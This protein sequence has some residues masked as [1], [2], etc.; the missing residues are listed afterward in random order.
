[1]VPTLVHRGLKFVPR[2]L[3]GMIVVGAA[4]THSHAFVVSHNTVSNDTITGT[5]EVPTPSFWVQAGFWAH[6]LFWEQT[7]II[8]GAV[9][10][11][12]SQLCVVCL[13]V[14]LLERKQA[15]EL[16]TCAQSCLLSHKSYK[17]LKCP[18]TALISPCGHFAWCKC[19]Y[20][21]LITSFWSKT[22][23]SFLL[24]LILDEFFLTCVP[25]HERY[26]IGSFRLTGYACMW[27]WNGS[28]K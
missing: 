28:R 13:L 20:T 26:L 8:L 1:M 25:R 22:G 17:V 14:W 5:G 27:F 3:E 11:L 19:A 12:L 15:V 23:R 10:S 6:S 24:S 21:C 18:W 7:Q 9:E 4:V 2:D 16:M